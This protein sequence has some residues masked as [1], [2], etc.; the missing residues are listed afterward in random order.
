MTTD[1]EPSDAELISAVRGGDTTAYGELFT[2]HVE[3]ARR[4]ARQLTSAGDVEDLVS[5]AFAK[6]LTIV[7]R[8]G[9]PDLAFRAYLLT[10]V[11]SL[12]IDSVRG[13]ARLR[14]VDDFAPFDDGVPVPRHRRRGLREPGGGPRVRDAARAVAAGAVAHRGRG[15]EARRGRASCSACPPTPSPPSPTGPARGCARRS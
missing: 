14:P 5:E 10:A 9:G 7:Q 8:G 13:A 11:R 6:V 15:P 1:A 4:L 2:R 3:A 12:H